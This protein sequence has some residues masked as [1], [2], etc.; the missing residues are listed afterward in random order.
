[1]SHLNQSQG[2]FSS[3]HY[4]VIPDLLRPPLLNFAAHYALKKAAIGLMNPSDIQVP[5]TPANY[6]DPIM[7]MLLEE[8]RPHIEAIAGLQLFSTYAYFRVYQPGAVL[9]KH[10]DR[11][12]CEI[13]VTLS[14]ASEGQ[15]WPIFVEHASNIVEI[16]LNPGD[17][18]LYR[19]CD[20]AHWR[21][22][23]QGMYQSQVFLH[24][25]DQAGPYANW[26]FDHRETLSGCQGVSIHQWLLQK[27]QGSMRD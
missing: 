23:F 19:G 1:M 13:S 6:G 22:E 14:L 8:L 10:R 4:Q 24:Y 11:P 27:S 18:L 20:V 9:P 15:R 21:E 12:A 16:H 17:G 25:V 26:K 2:Y 5:G 7:E 3:H